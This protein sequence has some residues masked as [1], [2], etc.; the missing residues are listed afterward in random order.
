M[1]KFLGHFMSNNRRERITNSLYFK[2]GM[3]CLAVLFL[4]FCV[5][6]CLVL[7][8]WLGLDS[9]TTGQGSWMVNLLG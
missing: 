9:N 8:W 4:V 6:G 5:G 2:Y 1:E 3:G 7:V